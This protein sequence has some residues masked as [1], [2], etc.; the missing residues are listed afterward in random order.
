MLA[1]LET[2]AWETLGDALVIEVQ[3]DLDAEGVEEA[4][5]E[6]DFDIVVSSEKVQ[7]LLE[8]AANA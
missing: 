6:Q 2:G 8:E 3:D 7:G 4:L 5:S 1:N